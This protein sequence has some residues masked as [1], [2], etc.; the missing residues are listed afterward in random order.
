MKG[1]SK[2]SELRRQ[3]RVQVTYAS[4]SRSSYSAW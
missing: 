4:S 1:S 3:Q 2:G